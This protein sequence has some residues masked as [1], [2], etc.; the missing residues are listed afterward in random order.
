MKSNQNLLSCQPDKTRESSSEDEEEKRKEWKIRIAHRNKRKLAIIAGYS[1]H[2]K[3]MARYL[4]EKLNCRKRKKS[5]LSSPTR[6]KS[7]LIWKVWNRCGQDSVYFLN[8]TGHPNITVID[9]G[10]ESICRDV[11]PG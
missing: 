1:D 8:N 7:S 11:F 10:V 3:K 2:S 4:Q 5:S 9:H 6:K